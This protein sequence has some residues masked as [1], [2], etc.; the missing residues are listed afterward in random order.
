MGS[1]TNRDGQCQVICDVMK[2]CSTAVLTLISFLLSYGCVMCYSRPCTSWPQLH[3]PRSR[4][5]HHCVWGRLSENLLQNNL[6][7]SILPQLNSIIALIKPP[8]RAILHAISWLCFILHCHHHHLTACR[9]VFSILPPGCVTF[10][11]R[12]APSVTTELVT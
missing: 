1:K 3:S 10:R 7:H 4:P 8:K 2:A 11:L 12:S 5:H 6:T 9:Q